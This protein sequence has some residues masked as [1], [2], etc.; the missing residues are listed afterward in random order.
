MF[1]KSAPAT[2]TMPDTTV[3]SKKTRRAA[4]SRGF[5]QAAVNQAEERRRSVTSATCRRARL[6]SSSPGR[7]RCKPQQR[8]RLDC[9]TRRAVAP[10]EACVAFL[11]GDGCPEGHC[12]AT[13]LWQVGASP[14]GLPLSG[15]LALQRRHAKRL[16]S[17]RPT[18][19]S[20]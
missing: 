8:A 19:Q 3:A 4:G 13:G 9:K 16:T 2:E 6:R 11:A 5:N 18:L 7:Q 17:G 1:G 14:R 15:R 12:L 20:P 10:S